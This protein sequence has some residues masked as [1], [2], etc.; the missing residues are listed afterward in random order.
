MKLASQLITMYESKY[1]KDAGTAKPASR[2]DAHVKK[3]VELEAEY[4]FVFDFNKFKAVQLTNDMDVD[5]WVDDVISNAKLEE[6]INSTLNSELKK[7][8]WFNER[9]DS[10]SA[11]IVG[12]EHGGKIEHLNGVGITVKLEFN[13]RISVMELELSP[14]LNGLM[15]KLEDELN[16]AGSKL[17]DHKRY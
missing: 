13:A 3:E 5:A 8:K 9:F 15:P 2:A 10:V 7:Q 17:D 1:V 12:V 16:T 14:V 4:R 6:T 11:E